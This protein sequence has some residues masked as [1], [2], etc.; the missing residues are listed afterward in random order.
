MAA[1]GDHGGAACAGVE[2]HHSDRL[3]GVDDKVDP[4]RLRELADPFDVEAM[5]GMEGHVRERDGARA[6]VDVGREHVG[7]RRLALQRQEAHLD[8]LSPEIQEGVGIVGMVALHHQH[9]VA[10]CEG[11]RVGGDVEALRRVLGEGDLRGVSADQRGNAS[12]NLLNPVQPDGLG[13]RL[14]ETFVVE[15]LEG[16]A[17]ARRERR[18][19]GRI[20]I[21]HSPDHRE[22][23][24][25]GGGIKGL[26]HHGSPHC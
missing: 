19:M 5:T 2:W 1:E 16:G 13:A 24:P 23:A 11:N 26:G 7:C 12:A 20:E 4:L 9:I 15:T 18:L 3:H 22:F 17:H 21:E 6:P 25:H 10:G 8:A 14:L